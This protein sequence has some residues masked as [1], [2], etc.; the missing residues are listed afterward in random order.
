MVG[1][2]NVLSHDKISRFIIQGI[3]EYRE[4]YFTSNERSSVR[5]CVRAC[6]FYIAADIYQSTWLAIEIGIL[7]QVQ[8]TL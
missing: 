6:V 7:G 8:K 5:V 1:F 4:L 2:T 3:S